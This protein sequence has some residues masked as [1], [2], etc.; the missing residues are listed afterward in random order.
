MVT[1][2]SLPMVRQ[3][4]VLGAIQGI[5]QS[6]RYGRTSCK[7]KKTMRNDLP[8]VAYELNYPAGTYVGQPTKVRPPSA[9]SS[10]GKTP[11][12]TF[13]EEWQ[14]Y[15]EAAFRAQIRRSANTPIANF[16]QDYGVGP[17]TLAS[18]RMLFV[19]SVGATV[20]IDGTSSVI[21]LLPDILSLNAGALWTLNVDAGN[22]FV[23]KCMVYRPDYYGA[24]DSVLIGGS[25]A[26]VPT[27]NV[28]YWRPVLSPSGGTPIDPGIQVVSGA[29]EAMCLDPQTFAPNQVYG[30]AS[31]TNRS[32]VKFPEG[33][34]TYS[35][36][37]TRGAGAA[38]PAG[39]I[40]GGYNG[41]LFLAVPGGTAQY[42]YCLSSSYS[43][44][45]NRV[46]DEGQ[47]ILDARYSVEAGGFLWLCSGGLYFSTAL[48][49]TLLLMHAFDNS[50]VK[51]I[52]ACHPTGYAAGGGS[53]GNRIEIKADLSAEDAPLGR[54]VGF[55]NI[56][57]VSSTCTGIWYDGASIWANIDTSGAKRL[58]RSMRAM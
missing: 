28:R 23:P 36:L 11:G 50:I 4:V 17:V 7:D 45:T 35:T 41:D 54:G 48:S 49:S 16:V 57:A 32:V 9:Q 1:L 47:T 53:S 52:G 27:R 15:I 44:W 51:T 18:T 22:T 43:T 21:K 55:G 3:L 56:G 14:N 6:A 24:G 58:V 30:F 20:M 8:R 5:P 2:S 38:S 19:P 26:G 13:A 25:C 12:A 42:T 10:Y 34:Y 33:N 39:Q 40:A 31:D 46:I 29:I 37:G